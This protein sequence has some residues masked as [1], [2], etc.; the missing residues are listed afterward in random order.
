MPADPAFG[1]MDSWLVFKL[2]GEHVTD[3]RK[4]RARRCS[5]S[6]RREWTPSCAT[7][8]AWTPALPEPRPSGAGHRLLSEADAARCG[9]RRRRYEPSMSA[10]H[11]ESLLDGRRPAVDVTTGEQAG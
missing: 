8:S 1:T 3:L 9:A 2:T 10:D 5:R 7:C 11:R 4:P 6:V